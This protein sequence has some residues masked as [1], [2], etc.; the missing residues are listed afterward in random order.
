MKTWFDYSQLQA[1]HAVRV[2]RSKLMPPWWAAML[3]SCA[4]TSAFAQS[5]GAV[6]AES[7]SSSSITVR[8]DES[9]SEDAA[10]APAVPPAPSPRTAGRKGARAAGAGLEIRATP[11]I[12]HLDI[13]GASRLSGGRHAPQTAFVQSKSMERKA[14]ADLAEDMAVMA[15]ILDKAAGVNEPKGV[16]AMNVTISLLGTPPAA[17]NLYLDD[18]GLVFFVT[19]RLALQPVPEETVDPKASATSSD[20]EEAKQDL[21][22]TQQPADE[23]FV[24]EVVPAKEYDAQK[25]DQLKNAV[26]EALK[27][28]THVRHLNP[29]DRIVVLISSGGPAGA[30]PPIWVG[31]RGRM[32]LIDVKNPAVRNAK[33]DEKSALTITVRKADVDAFASG[34]MTAEDFRKKALIV[35]D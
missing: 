20:W 30:N 26:L 32:D 33:A 21:Y 13:N 19:T 23:W 9:A 16:A 7:G 27:N 4:I 5:S 14:K 25:V 28:A 24:Q 1:R 35:N 8:V 6:A 22:G 3:V 29:L 2:W 11:H 17:R 15:R 31:S 10:N 12:E 18:Y 34:N